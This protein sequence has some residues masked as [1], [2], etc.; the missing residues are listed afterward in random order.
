[1]RATFRTGPVGTGAYLVGHAGSWAEPGDV[2]VWILVLFF[3][4]VPL[5]RW[6]VS[7]TP[8][9]GGGSEPEAM[10]LT[11]HS[12]SRL[13][14]RSALRRIFRAVGAALLA[15]APLGLGVWRVGSPWASPALTALFGPG[16]GLD[17]LGMAIE[18]GVVLA[19]AA[20]P[21]LV[22]AYLDERTPRVAAPFASRAGTAG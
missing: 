21:L 1:M 10:A 15:F 7:G 8:M 2:E 16:P 5:S 17:K 3:P 19:G 18:L 12:R 22:L 14:V 20:I 9:G 13:P 4:V 6:R 11:L